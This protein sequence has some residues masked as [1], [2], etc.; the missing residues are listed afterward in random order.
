MSRDSRPKQSTDPYGANYWAPPGRWSSL[1]LT[2]TQRR[3]FNMGLFRE[4]G[5]LPPDTYLIPLIK[6]QDP[7]FR[8]YDTFGQE[9]SAE[10]VRKAEE[11]Q[12]QRAREAQEYHEKQRLEAER[13]AK[14]RDLAEY[15]GSFP[16]EW[17]LD[18]RQR[19]ITEFNTMAI[20]T[21][22]EL[23]E[24]LLADEGDIWDGA[25]T[26]LEGRLLE[27]GKYD[28]EVEKQFYQQEVPWAVIRSVWQH[29]PQIRQWGLD[30]NRINMYTWR[31]PAIQARILARKAGQFVDEK[32]D[33]VKPFAWSSVISAALI[34]I[35]VIAV[36]A[37]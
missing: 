16:E 15:R 17:S 20:R 13:K 21:P 25:N 29:D 4:D 28:R 22:R 11:T 10:E 1:R 33:A 12:R 36:K 24:V 35:A 2:P 18:F 3:A 26:L 6:A 31:S 27:P 37:L 9:V 19:K 14:E 7:S 23:Y 5:E 32:I 34:A 8:G 30:D